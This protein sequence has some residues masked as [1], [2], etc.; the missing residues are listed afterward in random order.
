MDEQSLLSYL[1]KATGK[2]VSLVLTDNAATMLSVKNKGETVYLR[3]QRMFLSADSKVID[4]I[5]VFIKNTRTKTPLVRDFIREN[6]HQVKRRPPRKV[7]LRPEGSCHGLLEMYH[8]INREYF[9]DRVSASITWGA[10]GPRRAAARRTLGSYC[11]DSNMIRI[12]PVLDSKRVPRYF[13]EFIVYHEMLHADIGIKRVGKRRSV[14][15][16]EFKR[17]E[18]MFR[19]YER[20]IEWE[21]KRWR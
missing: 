2:H 12:N 4:E 6:I 17:R 21:K 10:K 1:Q 14:H 13:L 5:A 18:T 7:N 11:S 3:M 20:A 16:K 15:S 8:S 19:Y 9:D